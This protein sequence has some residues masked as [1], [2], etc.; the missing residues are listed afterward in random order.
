MEDDER[1][2]G[3]CFVPVCGFK[4]VFQPARSPSGRAAKHPCPDC[5]FCQQCGD[6]RCHACRK[7][8][9]ES[10]K[11]N[12]GPKPNARQ[13]MRPRTGTGSRANE[14]PLSVEF[15]KHAGS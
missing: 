13:P 3:N 10:K 12:P 8:G 15:P 1:L 6:D 4:L 14:E 5:H 11:L 7:G 2:D 9:T